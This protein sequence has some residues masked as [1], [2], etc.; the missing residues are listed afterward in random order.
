M[1]AHG[2]VAGFYLALALLLGAVYSW[3]WFGVV[4]GVAAVAY[5]IWFA[6]G[7]LTQGQSEWFERHSRLAKHKK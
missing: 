7:L 6:L 2:L 5:A 4:F 3:A 1:I